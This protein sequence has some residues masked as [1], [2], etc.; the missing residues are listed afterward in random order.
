VHPSVVS[1]ERHGSQDVLEDHQC[2]GIEYTWRGLAPGEQL[3]ATGET[4]APQRKP[5]AGE[6]AALPGSQGRSQEPKT[7]EGQSLGHSG[8]LLQVDA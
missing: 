2:D 8:L 6:E 5:Q 7:P 1:D 3:P 4:Y